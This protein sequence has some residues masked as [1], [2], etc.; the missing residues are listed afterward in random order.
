[1]TLSEMMEVFFKICA[2]REE[3]FYLK[4]LYLHMDLVA[5]IP[6]RNVSLVNFT[7]TNISLHNLTNKLCP[8]LAL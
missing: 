2:E 8:R 4:E 1:M 7:I 3:F 6:V 5:H